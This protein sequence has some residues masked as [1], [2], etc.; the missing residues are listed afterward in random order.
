[1]YCISIV[2]TTLKISGLNTECHEI[3]GVEPICTCY[4]NRFTCTCIAIG[5]YIA[6]VHV[7]I[8][9]KIALQSTY[10]RCIDDIGV[11]SVMRSQVQ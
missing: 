3:T 2:A 11:N 9:L 5:S 7:A 8:T 10:S 6:I 1:M 4:T